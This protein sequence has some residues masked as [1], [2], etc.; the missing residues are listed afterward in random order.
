MDAS[1]T[2][3]DG[4]ITNELQEEATKLLKAAAQQ[5]II[6]ATLR[7]LDLPHILQKAGGVM[8]R[9]SL[10]RLFRETPYDMLQSTLQSFIHTL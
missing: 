6:Y 8:S 5:L 2:K 4:E 7:I 10:D 3:Q 9:A 1:I